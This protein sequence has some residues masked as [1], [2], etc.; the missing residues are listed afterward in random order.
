MRAVDC[1]D[2][3]AA[4]ALI[5]DGAQINFL[6]GML[7]TPLC[8]AIFA[9]QTAMV[10]LLL[11][12]GCD[13]NAVDFDGGSPLFISIRKNINACAKMLI[14]A[15]GCDLNKIDPVTNQPPLYMAV[16]EGNIEVMTWL[17]EAGCNVNQKGLG[18]Q[19][20][21]QKA[22]LMKHSK[23]VSMLL[24]NSSVLVNTID[25][26]GFNPL[27]NSIL[28]AN[29]EI[30]ELLFTH[31]SV[32]HTKEL[33]EGEGNEDDIL[34]QYAGHDLYINAQSLFE[35]NTA[36]HLGVQIKDVDI[37]TFLI[38]QGID[39][40]MPNVKR[41]TPLFIACE[42]NREDIVMKLIDAGGN[43]N[44]KTFQDNVIHS[45]V[46]RTVSP[47]HLAVTYG[48]LSLVIKLIEAG[49]DLNVQDELGETPLFYAL[50]K[51]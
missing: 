24:S 18:G 35:K 30:F 36:L 45:C 44:C 16:G 42:A 50:Y 31:L 7:G 51:K 17:I 22:I 29:R 27:H 12:N 6:M 49:A 15:P 1:G 14:G 19:T 10:K 13:I 33:R 3:D 5:D 38:G 23:M 26:S 40:N 37:I 48:N 8:A 2:V 47:L 43:P 25:N 32:V 46:K 34:Y 4:Q 11:D 39:I 9:K 20:A 21:L 28:H 41:Q